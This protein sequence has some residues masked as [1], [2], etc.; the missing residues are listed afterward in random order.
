METL[1]SLIEPV[2]IVVLGGADGVLL[3]SILGPIY[4]ITAEYN[5]FS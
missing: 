5:R 3:I 1:V 4:N 2:M